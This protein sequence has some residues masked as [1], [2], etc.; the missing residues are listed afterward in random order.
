MVVKGSLQQYKEFKKKNAK[1]LSVHRAECAN[2]YQV[3]K[4]FQLYQSLLL[5]YELNYKPFNIWNINETGVPDIPK[6]Q[7]V[8]GLTGEA[9]L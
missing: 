6:E 2:A 9:T 4:F 5:Q 8:V 7:K 1:N 3:T